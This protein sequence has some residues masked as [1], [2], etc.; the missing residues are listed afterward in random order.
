MLLAINWLLTGGEKFTHAYGVSRSP[1]ASVLHWNPPGFRVKK[2]GFFSN[3]VSKTSADCGYCSSWGNLVGDSSKWIQ[4]YEN[5]NS[6]ESRFYCIDLL[7]GWIVKDHYLF[8]LNACRVGYTASIKLNGNG[9]QQS[10]YRRT[11][12]LPAKTARQILYSQ[13][14]FQDSYFRSI[15]MS[16]DGILRCC[17]FSENIAICMQKSR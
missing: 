13:G 2:A 4:I 9:D 14:T 6:C 11:Q 12:S 5:Q 1:H 17:T 16:R 8:Q 10:R 7:N 3:S 15:V